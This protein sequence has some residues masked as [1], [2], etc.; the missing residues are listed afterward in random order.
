MKNKLVLSVVR[1]CGTQKNSHAHLNPK[2]K[3]PASAT[4]YL[5]FLLFTKT[6][7]LRE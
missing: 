2:I 1:N 7:F 6:L 4:N 5:S 3:R